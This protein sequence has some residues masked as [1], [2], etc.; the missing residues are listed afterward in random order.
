MTPQLDLPTGEEIVEAVRWRP[1]VS[2]RELCAEFW[3]AMPWRGDDDSAA[4]TVREFTLAAPRRVEVVTVA[5]WLRDRLQDLVIN[6]VLD[7]APRRRDEPDLE[8]QLAYVVRGAAML[9][10]TLRRR[11]VAEAASHG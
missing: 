1:M 10:P 7:F 9:P 3:P 11:A 6:G 2:L 4:D 8:A 5:H